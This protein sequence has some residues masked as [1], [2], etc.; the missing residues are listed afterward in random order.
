[1]T[2][3]A[4]ALVHG[5]LSNSCIAHED[6]QM[7]F[8]AVSLAVVLAALYWS[9]AAASPLAALR[10]RRV[11]FAPHERLYELTNKVLS[12]TTVPG[13]SEVV[14]Q[15]KEN[16]NEVRLAIHNVR[17]E[18]VPRALATDM[19]AA[20]AAATVA[21]AAGARAKPTVVLAV[22]KVQTELTAAETPAFAPSRRRLALLLALAL[23]L[24]TAMLSVEPALA[25]APH[26]GDFVTRALWRAAS[27]PVRAHS[28]VVTT[29]VSGYVPVGDD[30]AVA[31]ANAGAEVAAGAIV[32]A[33]AQVDAAASSEKDAT[34]LHLSFGTGAVQGAGKSDGEAVDSA[35]GDSLAEVE[36][37][38]L[39]A[40]ARA[41]VRV[42]TA[43]A[44]DHHAHSHEESDASGYR[45]AHEHEHATS[46]QTESVAGDDAP[47]SGDATAA[48]TAALDSSASGPG[49]VSA[50]AAPAPVELTVAFSPLRRL[51]GSHALQS[52]AVAADEQDSRFR[53]FDS[54]PHVL[55]MVAAFGAYF[56]ARRRFHRLAGASAHTR[57][58]LFS[59]DVSRGVWD[60]TALLMYDYGL[61]V[62]LDVACS[63][64]VLAYWM[65]SLFAIVIAVCNLLSQQVN[66][67]LARQRLSFRVNMW[68]LAAVRNEFTVGGALVV[69][70]FA[71]LVGFAWAVQT[72][73]SLNH[74][75]CGQQSY[76]TGQLAA[77]PLVHLAV[78]V[79][80]TAVVSGPQASVAI[81]IAGVIWVA[82][83]HI[84]PARSLLLS[85]EVAA[86]HRA[87]AYA[88]TEAAFIWFLGHY[89]FFATGHSYNFAD[90]HTTAAFVI[91]QD[92]NPAYV[93]NRP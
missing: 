7:R 27:M 81:A 31:G 15:V 11:F 73:A 14:D 69:Y 9:D 1:V 20:A 30:D 47:D 76:A 45:H 50:P 88:A 62:G 54:L 43:P 85:T 39:D 24:L 83:A 21:A 58:T 51:D 35:H 80:V 57:T 63:G 60:F 19:V 22:P 13:Y 93:T 6:S 5:L 75:R 64:A 71:I 79:G 32:E 87:Y 23:P 46:S 42:P 78:A 3:A 55:Y 26:L 36:A 53:D 86:P 74:W 48:S 56:A 16:A 40:I 17:P 44:G 67:L 2:L 25:R 61:V 70:A 8:L 49:F 10:Q 28:S 34:A 91:S 33:E 66:A 65:P 92:F 90:L 89:L 72:V 18:L 38:A 59:W 41:G 84:A 68:E 77:T 29:A 52:G 37:G 12:H 4:I 82:L